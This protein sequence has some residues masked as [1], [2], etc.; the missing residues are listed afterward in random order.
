MT[1]GSEPTLRALRYR[2]APRKHRRRLWIIVPLVLVVIVATLLVVLNIAGRAVAEEYIANKVE[3]SLPAGVEGDVHVRIRGVFLL[4]QYLSGWMDE[5]DLSSDD[6]TV[7]GVP[8]TANVQLHGVPV[9]T[10]KRVERLT[11]GAVLDERAVQ[12]VLKGQG[13]PGDVA[14]TGGAVEYTDETQLF[15]ATVQYVLTA[16]PSLSA[17]RLDL[18]PQSAAV[19]S[20]GVDLDATALLERVAPDGISVCV[21]QYLPEA[22]AIDSLLV[23]DGSARVSLSGRDVLLTSDALSRTGSCS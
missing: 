14:L 20:G 12:A 9:D 10:S 19:R 8:V 22:I 3:E 6:L 18:A 23:G 2:D 13:Y 21:A 15:G 17:G 16:R 4:V 7:Q 11:G 1:I 5:V